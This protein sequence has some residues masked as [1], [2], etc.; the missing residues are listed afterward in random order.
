MGACI[1]FAMTKKRS[2]TKMQV[3]VRYVYITKARNCEPVNVA[4]GS[5]CMLAEIHDLRSQTNNIIQTDCL[6]IMHA[7]EQSKWY[8]QDSDFWH[9]AHAIPKICNQQDANRTCSCRKI[10]TRSRRTKTVLH[11]KGANTKYEKWNR[12]L[13]VIKNDI[14]GAWVHSVLTRAQTYTD[15]GRIHIENTHNA[16]QPKIIYV[17][18]HTR[19]TPFEGNTQ[20]LQWMVSNN[21]RHGRGCPSVLPLKRRHFSFWRDTFE[22]L[23]HGVSTFVIR[24]ALHVN[25]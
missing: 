13:H 9:V 16:Q 25:L 7:D 18:K 14:G 24:S 22:K 11:R 1:E 20:I 17:T 15:M 4:H 21:L 23:M 8:T 12:Y 2:A 10:H 5:K 6:H 3:H 19:S